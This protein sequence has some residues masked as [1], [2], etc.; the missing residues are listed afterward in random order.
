M[1]GCRAARAPSEHVHLPTPNGIRELDLRSTPVSAE[2]LLG[3]GIVER[4]TEF[5][6][7]HGIASKE[8]LRYYGHAIARM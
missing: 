6:V 8:S 5:R 7:A 2:A 1:E 4:V 3:Q